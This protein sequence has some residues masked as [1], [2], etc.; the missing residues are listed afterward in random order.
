MPATVETRELFPKAE[1]TKKDMKALAKLRLK[2]GA[3]TSVDEVDGDNRVLITT[4]NVFG[5]Q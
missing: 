1:T 4:W 5:Q 3:I 2:A